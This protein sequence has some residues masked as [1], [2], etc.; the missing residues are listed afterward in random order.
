LEELGAGIC[1]ALA[2]LQKILK[3]SDGKITVSQKMKLHRI[4][5]GKKAFII[6]MRN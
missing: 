5:G 3:G 1:R 6:M 2:S 4:R